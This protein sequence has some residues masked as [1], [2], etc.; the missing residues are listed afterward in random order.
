MTAG[1]NQIGR[2]SHARRRMTQRA[3]V[4][5]RESTDAR[6]AYGAPVRLNPAE[7]VADT[8]PCVAWPERAAGVLSD[9]GKVVVGG[10]WRAL[11]AGTAE[12]RIGDRVERIEDRR[13]RIIVD[14]PLFVHGIDRQGLEH[15]DVQLRA[16]QGATP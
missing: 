7:G 9:G 4:M 13:G 10:M 5:R 2:L 1:V 8:L 6:D 11:I 16:Q 12:L 14:G 15:F 3:V